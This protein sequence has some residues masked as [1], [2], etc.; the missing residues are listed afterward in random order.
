VTCTNKHKR[1]AIFGYV[2]FYFSQSVLSK[3]L[4]FRKEIAMIPARVVWWE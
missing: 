4:L 2:W 3:A 1:G